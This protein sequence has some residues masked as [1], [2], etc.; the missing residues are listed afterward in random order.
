MKK[1]IVLYHATKDAMKQASLSSPEEQKKGMETWMAWAQKCGD[2]L[3]D[4]GAPLTSGQALS[5][6]GKT[7]E[8]DRGVNGYSLLQAAN[9][10]E[11]I[12]LLQGHP[13]L[14]WNAECTIEVHEMRPLP[15]QLL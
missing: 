14:A 2:K 1:F 12:T 4:L 9:M 11:V 13:H 10:E 5:P 15:D 3:V 7:S 8:S 6:D